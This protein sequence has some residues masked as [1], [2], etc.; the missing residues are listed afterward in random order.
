V[1]FRGPQLALTNILFLGNTGKDPFW[2]SVW[3]GRTDSLALPTGIRPMG[4]VLDSA[5]FGAAWL[6]LFVIV[7]GA[8]VWL[9]RH[10]GLCP[11]CAYDLRG[12]PPNTPCPECG[13]C[14]RAA[15]A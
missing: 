9:R 5:C 14:R 8:R 2:R 15:S 10:R 12:L 7:P 13:V 3:T 6:F 11:C 4:F 1:R